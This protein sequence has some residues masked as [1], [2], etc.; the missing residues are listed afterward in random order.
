MV[1][2]YRIKNVIQLPGSRTGIHMHD[3]FGLARKWL[4]ATGVDDVYEITYSYGLEPLDKTYDH[5]FVLPF[6]SAKL[7]DDV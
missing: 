6:D 3:G 2:Q 4:F 7:G 1:E 5:T